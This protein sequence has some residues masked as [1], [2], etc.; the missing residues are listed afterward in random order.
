MIKILVCLFNNIWT[1]VNYKDKKKFKKNCIYI[2]KQ[3]TYF[4]LRQSS[5]VEL[6]L[7]S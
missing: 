7:P 6:S 4:M 5:E 1:T 2:K 3:K